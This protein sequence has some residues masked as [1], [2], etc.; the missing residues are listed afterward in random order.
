MS[1]DFSSCALQ[2][3]DPERLVVAASRFSPPLRAVFSGAVCSREG[4][5]GTA[6]QR[7]KHEI[8]AKRQRKFESDLGNLNT[9]FKAGHTY[10]RRINSVIEIDSP[11]QEKVAYPKEAVNKNCQVKNA[12]ASAKG[13]SSLKKKKTKQY[14]LM[15]NNT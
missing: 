14:F 11:K 4:R 6:G 5:G 1:P 15:Y 10:G 12:K 2:R 13:S 7:R 8:N 3:R 9:S